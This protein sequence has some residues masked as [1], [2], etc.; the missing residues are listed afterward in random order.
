MPEKISKDMAL[1]DVVT[2]FP[3]AVPTMLGYGLHCVGC[4]VAAFETIEQGAKA[5]GMTEKEIDKMLAEMNKAVEKK[6]PK[7]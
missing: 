2:K 3:A 4:H 1:G 5:H 6:E 7:R